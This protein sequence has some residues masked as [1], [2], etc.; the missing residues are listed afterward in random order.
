M[1]VFA[2]VHR[3]Y[4]DISL[5]NSCVDGLKKDGN[6]GLMDLRRTFIK[7]MDQTIRCEL[8]TWYGKHQVQ[9]DFDLAQRISPFFCAFE[10]YQE[11]SSC[12]CVG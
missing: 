2:I 3:I 12:S 11:A 8:R 4:I 6:E 9:L 5:H 10:N 1:S 7:S